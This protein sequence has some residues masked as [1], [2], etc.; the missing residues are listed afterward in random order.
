[1]NKPAPTPQQVAALGKELATSRWELP[2]KFRLT[3]EL[4]SLPPEEL[5]KKNPEIYALDC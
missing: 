4:L 2:A 5:Q 3:S 1:M